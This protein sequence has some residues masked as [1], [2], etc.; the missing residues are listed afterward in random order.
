MQLPKV[1]RDLQT[2]T[3]SNKAGLLCVLGGFLLNLCFSLDYSY[4]NL[5]TY[6][7]SY[8]RANGHNPGLQYKDFIFLTAAKRMTQVEISE[9]VF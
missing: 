7:T 5:N 8:M 2:F 9:T 1:C 6:L 4:A 3:R